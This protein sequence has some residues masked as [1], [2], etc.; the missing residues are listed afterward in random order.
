MRRPDRDELPP[1]R[2]I[3]NESTVVLWAIMAVAEPV[4]VSTD[5]RF[6]AY[7]RWDAVPVLA[8]LAHFSYLILLFFVFAHLKF[9]VMLPLGLIYSISISWNFNGI[10]HNFLHNPYFRSSFLNRVFSFIESIAC[11]F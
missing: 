1:S 4:R 7:S 2:L 10:S 9:W 3:S 5:S 6:F 11:G 8:E